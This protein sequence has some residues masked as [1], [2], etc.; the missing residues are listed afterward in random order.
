LQTGWRTALWAGLRPPVWLAWL[1][2]VL[3]LLG[4]RCPLLDFYGELQAQ[5]W[6]AAGLATAAAV[7]VRRWRSAAVGV[8]LVVAVGSQVA[9]H[10]MS[11]A[12][13]TTA[14]GPEPPL[15]IAWA[16]LR[17]WL[18][19]PEALQRLLDAEAPDIAVLTELSE[20]HRPAVAA[21]T[22]YAFRTSFPAGSAFDLMLMSRT[23]PTDVEFDYAHGVDFPILRARFC[24]TGNAAPCLTV[25]SVHAP[26]PPLPWAV[27]GAPASLRDT[28]LRTAAVTARRSLEA[29]DHVLLLGDFNATPYATAF[30]R[31]LAAS[32]LADSADT[33]AERPA[34]V[35]PTWFSS[36][37]GIGLPIDHAL[38]GPGIRIVER[39]LGPDIGS[40]HRPL[41][42]LLRFAD[43]P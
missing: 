38:V 6:V 20:N 9:P 13:L 11:P 19:G 17:N 27:L 14:G 4:G 39:R 1:F 41:V 43:A 25:I 28:L 5:A 32:G 21:A 31:T 16:N 3:A 2:A 7:A 8:L 42:L 10:L 37:P 34:F 30:R 40:D 29:G 26:G 33:P 22:R 15:R 12:R 35:R 18:T 23:R 36:W 24:P